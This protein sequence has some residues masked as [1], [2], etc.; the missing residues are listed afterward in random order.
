MG[1]LYTLEMYFFTS[2]SSGVWQVQ[3]EGTWGF[4]VCVWCLVRACFLVHRQ[5]PSISWASGRG[6]GD[7]WGL[8]YK[9]AN[10]I[11]E[12]SAINLVSTHMHCL[13]SP[14]RRVSTWIWGEYKHSVYNKMHSGT[15]FVYLKELALEE[16]VLKSTKFQMP[17]HQD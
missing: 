11:H 16:A 5:R 3:D 6:Q 9:G 12:E 10:S 1:G 14:G 2:H 7:F 15:Q 8:F 17:K 13:H 4:G